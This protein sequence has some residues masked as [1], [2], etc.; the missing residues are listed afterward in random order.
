VTNVELIVRNELDRMIPRTHTAP[1]WSDVVRRTRKRRMP[2]RRLVLAAAFVAAAILAAVG[3]AVVRYVIVGTPAPRAVKDRLRVI[4]ALNGGELIPKKHRSLGVEA[5]KTRAGAVL[6]ASTGPVYLWVAPTKRGGH[7]EFLQIVG[8]ELPDGRP[9][10][11]GG[12][13]STEPRRRVEIGNSATRVH[14]KLLGLVSGR[15]APPARSVRI[16]FGSGVR[17]NF[18]VSA[19]GFVLG[20]VKPR[21]PIREITALDGSGRVVSHELRTLRLSGRHSF[22]RIKPTGPAH[23]VAVIHTVRTHRPIVLRLW[24]GPNGTRGTTLMTPGGTERGCCGRPPEP[25]ELSIS[26]D[27]IGSASSHGMLILWGSV[28][29]K[30]ETVELRFEDGTRIELPIREGFVLY[31]IRPANFVHGRRP[32]ELVGRDRAGHVVTKRRLGPYAG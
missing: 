21:D 8:T 16:R 9:N 10:L 11:S 31:Q 5:E 14:G 23:T 25:N 15:A 29:S 18:S 20:E 4:D 27:Q 19:A 30:I 28:G 22:P 13:S 2:S 12:C 24:P 32:I 6:Q 1:D 3:Y 26:P 7:C 17:R